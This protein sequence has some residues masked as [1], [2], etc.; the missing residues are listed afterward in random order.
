MAGQII[1]VISPILLITFVGYVFARLNPGLDT[2]N[3]SAIVINIATPCLIFSTLTTIDIDP[4]RM[5]TM[6]GAAFLCSMFGAFLAMPLLHILNM[7][8]RTFLPSVVLPNSGNIGMP[9]VLLAFGQ[10]GLALGISYFFVIA[11]LQYTIGAGIASGQYRP[12][13]LV[14]Q[15]LVW[16][17]LSV[18][19]VL[20]TGFSVP[21]VIR[22]TTEI[23]G[24]MMIPAMLITL[25]AALA[26]LKIADLRP[27]IAI[28]VSRL[29][30]GLI[31]APIVILGLGLHGL[32]AGTVFLLAV[33]PTAIVTYVFAQ[34]YRDDAV[35]V[36]GGVVLSTI[37]TFALLPL[38]IWASYQVVDLT[39]L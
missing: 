33:M 9:L 26:N 7:S 22:T 13:E 32:E 4:S 30:I 5:V 35:Q 17:I 27:A 28:A 11:L 24:D 16:S 15:P 25:G 1:D 23:L 20:S 36:A 29:A 18:F 34:R 3:I 37:M 10:E 12:G 19:L 21:A 6:A 39:G 2:R 31:V 38:I 14:R 8:W